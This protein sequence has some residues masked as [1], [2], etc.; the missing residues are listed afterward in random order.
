MGL[1]LLVSQALYYL[2]SAGQGPSPGALGLRGLTDGH[3]NVS[4]E[5]MDLKEAEILSCRIFSLSSYIYVVVCVRV[6]V[7]VCPCA[8]HHVCVCMEA[9]RQSGGI[10]SLL[11]T[12]QVLGIKLSQM[13]NFGFIFIF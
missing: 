5:D 2:T 13:L 8:L 12:L 4:D 1:S 7:S 10:G 9:R 6:R 11:S 3:P